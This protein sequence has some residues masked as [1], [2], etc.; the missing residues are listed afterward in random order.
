MVK[1]PFIVY[2]ITVT[3]T[4]RVRSTPHWSEYGRALISYGGAGLEGVLIAGCLRAKTAFGK[5]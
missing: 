3:S 2:K 4:N 5:A 1:D